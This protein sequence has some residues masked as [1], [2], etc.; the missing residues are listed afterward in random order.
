MQPRI[1]PLLLALGTLLLSA[2]HASAQF[3]E[4]VTEAP[5]TITA[6]I[7]TTQV[8]SE[9]ATEKKTGAVVTTLKHADIVAD[10]VSY[11]RDEE[12]VPNDAPAAGWSLVTVN[13][14]PSDVWN[15]VAGGNLFAVNGN[16]RVNVPAV[17]FEIDRHPFRFAA[18][19]KERHLGRYFIDSAGTVTSHVSYNYLAKANVGG[20]T[21]SI[22]DTL[23][24][25][26]ATIGFKS[27][28]TADGFEVFFLAI[29]SLRA[30]ARGSF[31]ADTNGDLDP[32]AQGLISISI[33]TGAAKLV[34]ASTY[35]GVL[36]FPSNSL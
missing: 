5:V 25:G 8:I 31:T 27:K 17:K 33:A 13:Y 9:T 29:S 35:P 4:L 28:D 36:T 32:D 1:R 21:Y 16:L 12:L 15:V 20:T 11:L 3:I 19:Y 23:S 22:K 34:P 26:F 30:S 24:D 14:A 7:T 6:S 10:I 18:K 2:Q